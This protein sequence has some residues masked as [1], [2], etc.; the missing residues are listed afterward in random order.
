M[1]RF[2]VSPSEI[3]DPEILL[4][5]KESR[6]ALSVLRLKTG[7]QVHLMDGRG[8]QVLGIIGSVENSRVRVI[9]DGIAIEKDPP[10]LRVT[11]VVS[12]IRPER[13]EWLIEKS[14]ELG[15]AAIVPVV[16]ER[17]IVRLSKER[18]K[19]K[20]ERWRKIA[21]E[22]CKQCGLTELP[23]INEAVRL[24]DYL[25]RLPDFDRILV[26]TLAVPAEKI[27]A[28]LDFKSVKTPRLLAF[29][30]PEG[31]FTKKEVEAVLAK[32]GK[33]V[34]LGPLTLRS[35]TAAICLLSI[36]NFNYHELT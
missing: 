1:P 19:S 18:W 22:S 6:H 34:S 29:I 12:V 35:E 14:C 26:P 21:A 5:R 8:R 27:S 30:G 20:A 10:K 36:L 3:K 11:L 13:M 15:V 23:R 7:A 25:G 32:G 24:N 16:T 31:D 9:T 33:A 28:N 2:I 4:S 17:C